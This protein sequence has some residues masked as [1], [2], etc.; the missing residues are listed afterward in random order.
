MLTEQRGGTRRE[1]RE[2]CLR[3]G[4]GGP[5]DSSLYN[6]L[7]SHLFRILSHV[8]K[9]LAFFQ[10]SSEDTYLKYSAPNYCRPPLTRNRC[11]V[12]GEREKRPLTRGPFW[13]II[14][15]SLLASVDP[16]Q[17]RAFLV[18]CFRYS[19]VAKDLKFAALTVCK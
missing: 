14:S 12:G 6:S 1:R 2:G 15:K 8:E 11:H 7:L 5:T 17:L 9:I 3:V 16:L 4:G 13:D 10:G 18:G 19:F